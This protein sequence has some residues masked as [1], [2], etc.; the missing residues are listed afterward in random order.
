M[1]LTHNVQ[2]EKQMVHYGM[3]YRDHILRVTQRDVE[4]AAVW[5]CV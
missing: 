1:D 3:Y 2:C 4:V 5:V